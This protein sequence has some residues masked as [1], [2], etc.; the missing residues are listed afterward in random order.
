[1]FMKFNSIMFLM[2][3]NYT[4]FRA[5]IKKS[6]ILDNIYH[7]EAVRIDKREVCSDRN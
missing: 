1:M 2:K 4:G 5:N 7:I 6:Y 3:Q